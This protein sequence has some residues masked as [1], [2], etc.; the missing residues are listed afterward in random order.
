MAVLDDGGDLKG[1]KR[2][3]GTRILRPTIAISKAWSAI[4]MGE[5]SRHLGNRLKD[6]TAF[7]GVLSDMSG[8]KK[9]RRL[10]AEF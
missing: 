9:S 5:S 4:G 2:D 7:L 6:M 10:P 3:D 8:G 1:L